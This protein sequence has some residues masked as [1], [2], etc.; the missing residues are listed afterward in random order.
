MFDAAVA[1]ISRVL[2][3]VVLRVKVVEYSDA[4]VASLPALLLFAGD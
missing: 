2:P 4:I 3:E 1:V